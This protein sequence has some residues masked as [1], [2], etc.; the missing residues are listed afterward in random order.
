MGPGAPIQFLEQAQ[1]QHPGIAAD[2][3]DFAQLF[4]KKLWHEL[5]VKLT[6]AL[7]KPDFHQ[8][9]FLVQ[10]YRRA[11]QP[12]ASPQPPWQQHLPHYQSLTAN[13]KSH[14]LR[15]S[16]RV[17]SPQ[18]SVVMKA[19][20]LHGPCT[21]A[22]WAWM[23]CN[24]CQRSARPHNTSALCL[25][26]RN[27]I[28]NFLTR[29]NF[30]SLAKIAVAV[31]GSLPH[32]AD[33]VAFLD[34]EVGQCHADPRRKTLHAVVME[35]LLHGAPASPARI[36]LL[37]RMGPGRFVISSTYPRRQQYTEP[38]PHANLCLLPLRCQPCH[39]PVPRACAQALTSGLHSSPHRW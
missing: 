32:P 26:R 12:L 21:L 1:A 19:R 37:D 20:R 18:G 2:L 38:S 24:C 10:L 30:L 14:G 22:R 6:D 25:P 8:G 16:M 23:R 7:S 34:D 27:F 9:D 31:A 4:E 36:A 29:L 15:R 28:S 39:R 11:A 13:C 35:L 17:R 33:A 3:A 5:T